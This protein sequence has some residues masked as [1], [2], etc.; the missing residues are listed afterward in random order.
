MCTRHTPEREKV[1]KKNGKE[2]AK[3]CIEEESELHS[4]TVAQL[5]PH[6][7]QWLESEIETVDQ[8]FKT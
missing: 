2:S 3:P 6:T 8:K 5:S 1:L 7:R 4:S